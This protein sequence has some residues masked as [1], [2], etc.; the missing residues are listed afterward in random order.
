MDEM[1]RAKVWLDGFIKAAADRRIT[2]PEDIKMLLRAVQRQKLADAHPHQ[3]AEGV[4]EAM[5]K[6]GYLPGLDPT[7]SG[8]KYIPNYLAFGIPLAMREGARLG[9]GAISSFRRD[10]PFHWFSRYLQNR[11][12]GK[13]ERLANIREQVYATKERIRRA[14]MAPQQREVH[15]VRQE[16]AQNKLR[17]ARSMQET[18][19]EYQQRVARQKQYRK[20]FPRPKRNQ[21]AGSPFLSRYL[22]R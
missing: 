2:E 13:Q 9:R 5:E 15:D 17:H 21:Q 16:R 1:E 6:A 19:L 20:H 4:K 14:K 7:G 12:A 8:Y 18:G 3:Y 10:R 22:P 11:E